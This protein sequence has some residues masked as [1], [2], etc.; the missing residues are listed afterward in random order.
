MS[1]RAPTVAA[2][3]VQSRLS[4]PSVQ[5]QPDPKAACPHCA[6]E[7]RVHLSASSSAGA[8]HTLQQPLPPIV[9]EVLAGQ[10]Q[11]LDESTCSFFDSRFAHDFGKVRVHTDSRAADSAKSLGARAWTTGRDVVFAAGE[12]RPSTSQGMRLLAHELTHVLQQDN[13]TQGPPQGVS[14]PAD[15][16]EREADHIADQVMQASTVERDD[17]AANGPRTHG[18]GDMLHRAADDSQGGDVG[19]GDAPAA[20]E[21]VGAP[22]RGFEVDPNQLMLLPEWHEVETPTATGAQAVHRQAAAAAPTMCDTPASMQKVTSG[23]FLGGKTLDDYYP[24]LV[25]QSIWGTND[26]A[27]PFDNGKRA[28]SA[29]QLIGLLPIPCASSTAPTTLG[30]TA[31]IV[32]AKANGAQMME[33]GRPLAGQTLN[34]IQRSGRNASTTPFRQTWVGA[35]SMADPISGIPYNTLTSYEWEVN[36]NT[37]LTGTGGTVSV[38]WGVTVEATGGRVTKNEVR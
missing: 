16:S 31:T 3:A 22:P 9:G 4:T 26:A 10:S 34:D 17:T 21:A 32:R 13:H 35:V 23:K 30:Q 1:T 18:D 25:G 14:R 12:Y 8:A 11:P 15:P 28:G 19:A 29:V 33:G 5:R 37:S 36:L 2:P 7:G 6:D 38:G 20:T 27:G 24:D